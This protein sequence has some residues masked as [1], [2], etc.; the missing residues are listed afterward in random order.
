V[1][2]LLGVGVYMLNRREAARI[3]QRIDRLEENL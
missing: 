1:M 2:F 3:Q